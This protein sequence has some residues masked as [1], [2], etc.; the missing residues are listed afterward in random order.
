MEHNKSYNYGMLSVVKLIAA[1][2]V[3]MIHTMAFSS[4]SEDLWVAT[5]LGIC[6]V[7]VPFFFI[8]SGYF[9]YNLKDNSERM[10]RIKKY[11]IFYCKAVL[12][13]VVISI[14][15]LIYIIKDIPFLTL[16]KG[17]LFIGVTGSLWYVS[18]MIIGLL[19]ITPFLK[20]SCYKS[21]V[22]ISII[23]FAFGLAGDSYYGIFS[24][25]IIGTATDIYRNIFIM[26]QVG[27]TASVP[28]LTLG[29]LVN[30]FNIL[31]KIKKPEAWIIVGS[32][33]L[34]IETFILYKK[35]IALDYNLY[36]SLLILAPA[37]FIWTMNSKKKVS[38]RISILCRKLSILVY[39][40]HQPI[41]ILLVVLI[42]YLG[43]N[44]VLKF[45]LTLVLAIIFSY[46]LIKAKFDKFLAI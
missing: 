10:K 1:I 34:L 33:L 28:F 24:N 32:L 31:E 38:E 3:V 45:L 11:T 43:N 25:T 30:K 39:I 8:I 44:S 42:P 4:L 5:S 40:V 16:I 17:L 7:A 27:V 37:L 21:L 29:I 26:M 13:E 36:I 14:V 18:S 6:R 20:K 9:F 23:F 41:A 15:Y 35:E 46:G 12:F 19:F 2:L 22:I